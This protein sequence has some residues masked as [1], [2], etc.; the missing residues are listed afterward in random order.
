MVL[1]IIA[2]ED[3]PVFILRAPFLSTCLF[4]NFQ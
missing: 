2:I 1:E 4:P 3:N